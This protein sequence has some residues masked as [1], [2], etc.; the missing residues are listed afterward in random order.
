MNKKELIHTILEDVYAAD[1]SL[2]A[3]EKTLIKLIENLLESKPKVEIDEQFRTRLRQELMHRIAELKEK[4]SSPSLSAWFLSLGALRYAV[5][6]AVL[7]LV[8]TLGSAYWLPGAQDT[9]HVSIRDTGE[10]RAFGNL[11]DEQ[12]QPL[13]SAGGIQNF[14]VAEPTDDIL[15]PS[16]SSMPAMGLGGGGGESMPIRYPQ[17]RYE[18]I[19]KGEPLSL[20]SETVDVLK[21]IPGFT[22]DGSLQ[23]AINGLGF[24]LINLRTF[25]QRSI[26]SLSFTEEKE[27]GYNVMLSFRE[28]SVSIY[29]NWQQWPTEDTVG[30]G[31]CD[32]T[33]VMGGC[34]VK[35]S[36]LNI[37]DVPSEDAIISV[38][39]S[40]LAQH[41]IPTDSYGNARLLSEWREM[42]EQQ[43]A[44]GMAPYVPEIADV[45]YPLLINGEEVYDE[46]G[47]PSGMVINVDMRNMKVTSLWGL[48]TQR[49]ESSAYPAETDWDRIVSIARQGGTQQIFYAYENMYPTQRVV[50]ITL[51]TP[52]VQYMKT[53]LPTQKSS[54]EIIVPSVI[55]PIVDAPS[56]YDQGRKAIIVPLAKEL[57]DRV[58][59]FA[60]PIPLDI[61]VQE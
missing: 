30:I 40:F 20:E 8:V 59:V 29:Q 33:S 50:Y 36:G 60:P 32:P 4:P 26:E 58:D 51:G 11:G 14:E 17:T 3:H 37:Q 21:R 54:Q 35:P 52:S 25:T 9:W 57:L 10:E 2:R 47:R 56:D 7:V 61:P 41:D 19:Y 16:I 23:K 18:Y 24:G 22:S 48:M 27:Y 45:V 6:V 15:A 31:G 12:S 49:Y 44:M 13:P 53:W 38:A 55:F 28:G 1:S 46:G 5:G 34:M 42:Y 39:N 43:K